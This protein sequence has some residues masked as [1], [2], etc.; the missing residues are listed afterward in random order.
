MNPNCPM[1]DPFTKQKEPPSQMAQLFC[2]M[3]VWD[4]LCLCL[5]SQPGVGQ[6]AYG[7]AAEQDEG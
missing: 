6:Q 2:Q 1:G 4:T 5:S 3:I 7:T